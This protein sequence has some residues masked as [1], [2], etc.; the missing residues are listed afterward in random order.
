MIEAGLDNVTPA[1]GAALLVTEP[2]TVKVV[3]DSV[4][5]IPAEFSAVVRFV[6]V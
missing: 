1:A 4:V 5:S 2:A 6:N 3:P